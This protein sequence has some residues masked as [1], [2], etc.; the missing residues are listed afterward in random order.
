MSNE[1]CNNYF[2]NDP[3][4]LILKKNYTSYFNDTIL[5]EEKKNVKLFYSIKIKTFD[6]LDEES[7]KV[8][9]FFKFKILS[10]YMDYGGT[11][12]NFVLCNK[13]SK[14][15]QKIVDGLC[16]I[17]LYYKELNTKEN[18]RIVEFFLKT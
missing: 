4:I 1:N 5:E 17:D 12:W 11:K 13:N 18:H 7:K 14:E 2:R 3:I 10:Q 15:E 8:K 6:F 16:V 9:V